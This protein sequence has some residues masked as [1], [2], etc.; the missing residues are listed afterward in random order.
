MATVIG[1][2]TDPT[3]PGV[4]GLPFAQ[5]G[6]PGPPAIGVK[7]DGGSGFGI[8]SGGVEAGT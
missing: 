5:P 4:L 6:I 8:D 1:Q 7:G 2:A 3:Q